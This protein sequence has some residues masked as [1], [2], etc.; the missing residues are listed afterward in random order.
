MKRHALKPKFR[1]DIGHEA[2]SPFHR[3]G[4]AIREYY[5]LHF[6][7]KGKGRLSTE[8]G[9]FSLGKG[10]GFLIS[11]GEL[12][13]YVADGK[14]P[15]EYLWIG[16]A[17][18]TE[19]RE[20]LQ[21]HGLKSGIHR[22]C[23]RDSLSYLPF[24]LSLI[25]SGD[26]ASY[27]CSMAAFYQL[28]N[29]IPAAKSNLPRSNAVITQC[30]RYLESHYSDSLSVTELADHVNVSR[31]QLYRLFQAT[32]GISPQRAILEF[33][34]EK[35]EELVQRGGVSMTQIA[36]SCGFCDLSHFSK[37]YKEHFGIRPKASKM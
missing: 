16:V 5:L 36:F 21:N 7:L 15:W 31:S 33:R 6:I 23:Y 17:D 34:L 9:E 3:F 22:F 37:A 25:R 8:E 18:R 4:P 28:M 20:V 12:T 10:E 2:C 27:D 29:M 26:A 13:T 1:T 30:Y 14:E 32:L 11:P 19:I 35:A 24:L